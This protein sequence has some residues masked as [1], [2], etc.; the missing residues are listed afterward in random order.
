[1][2]VNDYS[3]VM[4]KDREDLKTDMVTRKLQMEERM[5]A[6]MD[7]MIAKILKVRSHMRPI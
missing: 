3:G 6:E 7:L 2:K 4:I 5:Q 1:M